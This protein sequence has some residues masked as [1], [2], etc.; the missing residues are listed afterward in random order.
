MK[1]KFRQIF[2]LTVICMIT[3]ASIIY[4]Q[5]TY[6]TGSSKADD[7][8][9][10][11]TST[12]HNWN[13]DTK[14]FTGSAQFGLAPGNSAQLTSLKTLTFSLVTESLKSGENGLDKNAYKA[15]K[16]SKY[17]NIFY[18]LT[19]AEVV[20]A[21]GNKFTIKTRGNLTIAGVTKEVAMD[22]YA[23]INKDGTITCVGSDKLKMTDY[24]V[25]P[26]KFMMGAMTTGDDITLAFTLVYKQ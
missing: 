13:M 19:S 7:M 20:P 15:L 4:A 18:K 14:T 10:S 26:P 22:V 2:V 17:K 6:V 3:S 23:T 9:L 16:T 21:K 5:A 25:A 24:Q 8:K 1:N 11:G 12:L